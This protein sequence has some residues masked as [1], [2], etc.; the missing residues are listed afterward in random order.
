MFNQ[1][2]PI[3]DC[4]GS[5]TI[6]TATESAKDH[7]PGF[8]KVSDFSA[9]GAC[10]VLVQ[11]YYN[12]AELP[13]DGSITIDNLAGVPII[14]IDEFNTYDGVSPD[15]INSGWAGAGMKLVNFGNFLLETPNNIE[16]GKII[17]FNSKIN[18]Y[19]VINSYK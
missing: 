18:V 13:V 10:S 19:V 11:C 16:A 4:L 15:Q 6:Q 2:K 1:K 14:A 8:I 7:Y 17:P 9:M 12:P 3:S 5:V